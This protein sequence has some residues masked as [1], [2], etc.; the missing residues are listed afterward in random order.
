MDQKLYSLTKNKDDVIFLC[1][2][3][4]NSPNQ[5]AGLNDLNK[6]FGF[7]GYKFYHNSRKSSRGVGVLI[8][9]KIDHLVRGTVAD[10]EDNFLLLDVDLNGVRS[11]IGTI[12]GPNEDDMTFFDNLKR[13]I[14]SLRNKNIIIGGDWNAT[15]DNS[16]VNLNIDT[17]NMIN[18]PSRRRSDKLRLICE[19]LKLLDPYRMFYPT[20]KEYTF[21]PSAIGMANRS[22]LDFFIISEGIVNKT[23]SCTIPHSL[24][25]TVFDHNRFSCPLREKK[26]NTNSKFLMLFWTI[27]T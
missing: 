9:K 24:S 8:S 20:R 16:N 11:T 25:S 22:R 1:D 13:G 4:L 26:F 21:I 17:V 27:R 7:Y 19:E 2:I 5:V 6:K 15:W 18:I 12:Y 3:R 10:T 14:Q 23:T